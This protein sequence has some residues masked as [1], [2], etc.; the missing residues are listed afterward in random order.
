MTTCDLKIRVPADIKQLL[1]ARAAD[2]DRTM[3]GEVLA[4]LKAA[5]KG[6]RKADA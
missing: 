4:L 5:L 1:Q 6:K 3:N 2:N